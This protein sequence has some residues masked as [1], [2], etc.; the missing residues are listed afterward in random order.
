L[1]DTLSLRTN[2]GKT[3]LQLTAELVSVDEH[4]IAKS[5]QPCMLRFRSSAIRLAR[6]FLMGVPLVMGISGETQNID[7]EI[8]RHKEDYR[9]SNAIRVTLHPRAGTWNLPE[10]YEAEIV[11]RSNLPWTKELVRNWK[12]TFYVWMSLYVYIG[13]LLTLL[14][15]YRPVLFMVTPQHC[16]SE[17]AIARGEDG[18][19]V[20]EL[21]R[22][23]RRSRGKR[24]SRVTHGGVAE[25]VVGSSASSIS[26][27]TTRED[28]TSVSV[29]DDVEDSESVCLS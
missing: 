12:W 9:R 4:V 27:T 28:V 13:L 24:K 19:E 29:E 14:C 2:F 7:V 18:N 26:M 23:W 3:F 21:L 20:C 5:S 17:V 16:S 25:S 8:L 1:S 22:K 10:L 15:C 11:M 6:S